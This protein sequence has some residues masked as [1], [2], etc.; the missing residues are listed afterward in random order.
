MKC[1]A[2][3]PT[4]SEDLSFTV[5]GCMLSGL[6]RCTYGFPVAPPSIPEKIAMK[7]DAVECSLRRSSIVLDINKE[8]PKDIF[9][10]RVTLSKD[11]FLYEIQ[12]VR[13]GGTRCSYH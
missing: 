13:I 1:V 6:L 8:G 11:E 7:S 5:L 10:C 4:F 2:V 12:K 9:L 3:A